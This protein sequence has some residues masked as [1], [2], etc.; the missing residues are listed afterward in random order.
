MK[1]VCRQMG[2]FSCCALALACLLLTSCSQQQQQ[3]QSK[4]PARIGGYSYKPGLTR[5]LPNGM[6]IPP[7]DAPPQV[8]RLVYAAN[9][10]VGKPYRMGGGH[11]KHEDSGYDCSGSLSFALRE[12]GL[13]TSVRHSRNFLRY[14]RSGPGKWVSVYVRNGHVFM[15]VCGL[16]FDTTGKGR[17]RGPAWRTS[18]RSTRGFYVRHPYGF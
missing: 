12:A 14:G 1:R 17:S 7:A 4:A 18:S 11:R 13:L 8:K 16:R 15:V 9:K 3:Q 10:L 2:A 5:L 6:A